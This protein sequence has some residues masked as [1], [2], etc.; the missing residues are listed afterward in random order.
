MS[1]IQRNNLASRRNFWKN[2]LPFILLC[3]PVIIYLLL[4]HY[5]PMFGVIL[6]FKD[7]SYQR[8]IF[9]S[10]WV[11]FENFEYFFQSSDVYHVLF[12][13]IGYHVWFHILSTVCAVAVALLLYEITSKGATKL[14]QTSMNIPSM[15]SAGVIAYVVYAFLSYEN[16][17]INHFIGSFGGDAVSW[18]NEA[19]YWPGILSIVRVW[20]GIGMDSVLY[21]GALMSVDSALYEAASL[22][23]AGRFK[24]VLHISIPQI[25][26]I[27][28]LK[29]ILSLGSI[30]SAGLG[31]FYQ[32]PMG[33]TAILSTTDV[34]D[35][36]V[37][38]GV[39]GG[40]FGVSAA[41][42]LFQ[43]VVG[44]VMLIIVN[45]ITRK[46]SPENSLF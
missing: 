42:G 21:Y 35:T 17:F 36:Y 16:G 2:N 24:Q 33:S 39:L 27:I 46:V 44:A 6:A 25:T 40:D 12:N 10:P 15:V 19:K 26:P 37:L 34:I 22:D 1:R 4:F 23:G 13:T 5:A 32:V 43:S 3:L 11:G 8:G 31:L 41:V 45:M 14:F 9:G 18:Y 38:R 7:Y 30:M 20:W 28:I 29:T